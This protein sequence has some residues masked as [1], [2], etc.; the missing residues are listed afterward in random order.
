MKTS[1]GER[2]KV[3]E[4]ELITTVNEN[5]QRTG[6][7]ALFKASYISTEAQFPK[8]SY[9]MTPQPNRIALP[10]NIS[11]PTNSPPSLKLTFVMATKDHT[12][13]Q[14]AT[15]SLLPMYARLEAW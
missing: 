9:V 14:E 3:N 7:D 2:T 4:R 5:M 12:R 13:K 8:A 1:K 11:D 6:L 10:D 15:T